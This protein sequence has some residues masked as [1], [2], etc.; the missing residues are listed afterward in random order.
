M[1][2]P[3]IQFSTMDLCNL[4][5][6][7]FLS[8]EAEAAVNKAEKANPAVGIL[9]DAIRTSRENLSIFFEEIASRMDRACQPTTKTRKSGKRPL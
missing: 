4:Q 9:A 1:S 8:A 6:M 2:S 7:L 3:S 5:T